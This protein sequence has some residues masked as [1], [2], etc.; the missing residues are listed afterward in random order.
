MENEKIVN[1]RRRRD[2]ELYRKQRREVMLFLE[3]WDKCFCILSGVLKSIHGEPVKL[4]MNRDLPPVK[5]TYN[6]KKDCI[7]IYQARTIN[8]EGTDV[9][10]PRKLECNI[11]PFS[12]STPCFIK[13]EQR[14]AEYLLDRFK[15]IYVEAKKIKKHQDDKRAKDREESNYKSGIYS[16]R[17]ES[18]LDETDDFMQRVND[19][20][21]EI[22]NDE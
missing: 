3:A 9:D 14:N 12:T 20:I 4:G 10:V 7:H 22:C 1:E 2:L 6:E 15:E 18:F 8:W 17:H 21:E 11:E 13:D 16:S 19:H 5:I